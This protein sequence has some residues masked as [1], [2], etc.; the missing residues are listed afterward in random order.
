MKFLHES[1][2]VLPKKSRHTTFK[3]N[4][5]SALDIYLAHMAKEKRRQAQWKIFAA[6]SFLCLL[7]SFGIIIWALHLPKTVPLVITV[8]DWGEAK[9]V[10]SISNYSYTGIKIPEI[11]I[12]YQFR[13]FV[14]NKFSISSDRT[15]V[16][17]NL[18]DCYAALTRETATKLSSELRKDNPLNEAGK[19]T[20]SVDI[21]SI[22]KVSAK[23]YQVDFIVTTSDGSGFIKSRERTRGAISV[24]MMEP[25]EEDKMLNPLGIYITDYDF[26]KV[27]EKKQ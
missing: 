14:A 8:S 2:E 13:K 11:A 6:G 19:K 18:K 7:I 3:K 17:N 9:Y 21:E 4:R 12:E 22:L 5:G 25:A 15:V 16:R 10:G 24:K 1:R 26:K 27:E 20:V 23:T